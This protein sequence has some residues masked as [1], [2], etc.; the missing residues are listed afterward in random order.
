M[1]ETIHGKACKTYKLMLDVL[2]KRKDLC[3]HHTPRLK[4][5]RLKSFHHKRMLRLGTG[6]APLA[7]LQSIVEISPLHRKF[8]LVALQHFAH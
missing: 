2:P 5:L 8:K 6:P 7:E 3:V 4:H 1:L